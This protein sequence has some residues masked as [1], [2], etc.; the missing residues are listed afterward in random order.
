[1]NQDISLLCANAI[2]ALA[3]DGVQKANSGHPGMPMGMADVSYVLWNKFLKHNP[4]DPNWPDR[5]RFVLSA[6]HGSMLIYSL[7]HL[8]GYDLPME[9]LKNF[10]QWNSKTPGHPEYGHTPGVETTT[11]PLGQGISTAVGMALAESYLAAKFNQPD[12]SL[13]DHYTYVIASDGDLMEGV[14]HE[15]SSLAGHLKLGKLIVMYDRNNISIDGSTD[16]S[17]TEDVGKRYEAYGWQ[18]QEINAHDM[19]EIEK[20]LEQAKAD[21]SRP[22]MIICNAHIAYGSPNKQDTAGAHGAPLGEDEVKLT[23][24]A[25]GWPEEPAFH[26]PDEVYS[27]MQQCVES[28]GQ[29]Q[30]TWQEMLERYRTAHPE[31]AARWDEMWERKL[32][33]NWEEVLPSFDPG[34]GGVATRSASGQVINALAPVIPS[35]LGGSADLHASNNTLV[36][37]EEPLQADNNHTG[38]NIYYGVREHAMGTVMNGMALHGG[39]IPFGGTFLVFSDY[40]RPAIR[41]AAMMGIQVVY[42]FTHDSIGLGEDGPTHQPIEH[43]QALRIIPNLYTVRPA[44]ANETAMAWRVAL[45]RKN[46]PTA[47]VLTRQKVATLDRSE[48]G[49]YGKLGDAS[50][51]LR[52]AYVLYS[53]DNPDLILLATGSEVEIALD[54]A[55][56]LKEKNI[57][58]RVVSMPCWELFNQQD[59]E[60]RDSVLPPS[61]ETRLG[62][63]ASF[64]VGWGRYFT[65]AKRGAVAISHFGASAPYQELYKQFG[66][67]PEN[68]AT[69]AER[70]LNK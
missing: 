66:F 63:E 29:Q 50:G 33:E 68:V 21:T 19:G 65:G 17:F 43:V 64:Q 28:G 9:E 25:L 23:K 35:L 57:A 14:S 39:I 3:M 12:F 47:L 67:T 18:V 32:P 59:Q 31:L 44:D 62:V 61:V 34:A 5:D 37:G 46:A 69:V 42:V 58:A 38:R 56:L 27:H 53:P 15:A 24:K 20:A 6:G 48:A 52:G 13:V 22:S 49:K 4:K 11:G 2:R 54:A 70:L 1:M 55:L 26:V 16:L 7:L 36:K 8:T 45:E 41:L 60:Y 10:R 51:A 40:M 30:K